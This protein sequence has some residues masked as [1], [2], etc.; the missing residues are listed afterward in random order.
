M[1]LK[2]EILKA[3]DSLELRRKNVECRLD[4][5]DAT[6]FTNPEREGSWSVNQVLAHL[7]NA[8]FGTV[9]YI[10]KK[11]Q[12]MNSLGQRN[13]SSKIRAQLLK[14]FL[15]SPVKFKMPKKMPEPTNDLSFSEL[16]MQFDKNRAMLRELI[17][18]F[19]QED[20][21]KLIFKHPFAGRFSLHQTIVFLENHYKH[22]E[23]QIDRILVSVENRG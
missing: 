2:I 19:P 1:E 23:K 16:K 10:Q 22:H 9:R 7:S 4:Q 8:E 3:F 13:F 20:L 14:W 15:N 17:E 11:M 18:S 21:D 5:L 12:G 6:G